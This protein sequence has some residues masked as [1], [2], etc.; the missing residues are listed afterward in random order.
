MTESLKLDAFDITARARD[1]YGPDGR[2]ALPKVAHWPICPFET[3][4]LQVRHLND[5]VV[6]EPPRHG[7]AARECEL[8]QTPDDGF[9]WTDE[10]WRVGMSE[11]PMA[12]P[13]VW[14]HSR[15]HL[16][17]DDLTDELAA[18]MGVRIAWIQRALNGIEGVARVHLN[19]WGDGGAHFHVLLVAPRNLLD[20]LDLCDPAPAGR[21]MASHAGAR[22]R[23]PALELTIRKAVRGDSAGSVRDSTLPPVVTP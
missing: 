18:E 9:L 19:R 10:H 22:D 23:R 6:P 7:E 17:F 1:A 14:L 5:P 13:N 8:C 3:D 20:D 12:L 16:D 4:T 2:L 15:E 21:C 11:E